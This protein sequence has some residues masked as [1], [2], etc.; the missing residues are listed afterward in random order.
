M[1]LYMYTFTGWDWDRELNSA[2][3][4]IYAAHLL[5]QLPS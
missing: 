2:M 3:L 1:F 4:W 5:G